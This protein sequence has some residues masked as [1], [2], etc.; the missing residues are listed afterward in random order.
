MP[1]APGFLFGTIQ[2][3]TICGYRGIAS[4]VETGLASIPETRQ[5]ASLREINEGVHDTSAPRVFALT[6][7][8]R[9]IASAISLIALRFCRL[10]FCRAR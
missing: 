10:C 2:F 5:A 8:L 1:S 7:S 6:S 4:P 9:I 3:G